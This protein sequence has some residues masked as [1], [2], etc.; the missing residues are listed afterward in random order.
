[1][2]Q[3]MKKKD[4]K[5]FDKMTLGLTDDAAALVGATL[6]YP[7]KWMIIAGAASQGKVNILH[8]AFL[9]AETTHDDL[10]I[11]GVTG[12]RMTSA[13][14]SFDPTMA[15]KAVNP[16]MALTQT[17]EKIIPLIQQFLSTKMPQ[18]F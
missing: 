2:L 13:L 9:E 8:H 5:H 15:T 14:K 16:P 17:G 7:Y 18:E 11:V 12:N 10:K 1:M 6:T 4:F 3:L